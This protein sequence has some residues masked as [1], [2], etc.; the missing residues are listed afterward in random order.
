NQSMLKQRIVMMD[1][2]RSDVH[3]LWKYLLLLPVLALMLCGL[4]KPV[5][6]ASPLVTAALP[7]SNNQM[8]RIDRPDN[9]ASSKKRVY[10]KHQTSSVIGSQAPSAEIIIPT[11]Q[12][13]MPEALADTSTHSPSPW[14]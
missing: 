9:S 2:K 11:D 14:Q 6:V 10:H 8:P 7:L 13:V 1:A 12:T 5:A 3:T 4:N